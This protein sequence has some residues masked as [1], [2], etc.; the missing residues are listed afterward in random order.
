MAASFGIVFMRCGLACNCGP[1]SASTRIAS[2]NDW[3]RALM[4]KV[5][6]DSS[7]QGIPDEEALQEFLLS[8]GLEASVPEN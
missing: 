8:D 4:E 6:K 3:S 2:G 1:Q 5:K 7:D